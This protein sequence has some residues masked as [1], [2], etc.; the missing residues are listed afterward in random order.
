M[1]GQPICCSAHPESIA[2]WICS[3]ESCRRALCGKCTAHLLKLFTCCDC[4]GPARRLTVSRKT[5]SRGYWVGAAIR[6]PFTAGLPVVIAV[7]LGV[8]A[9]GV[10]ASLIEARPHQL[11]GVVGLVRIAVIVG[12]MLVTIDRTARSAETGQLLRLARIAVGTLCLWLPAASHVLLLG[13]PARVTQHDWP[14]G[15]LA[16]LAVIY[17][18]VV[19][20]VAITDTS[21]ATVS[22]PFKMFECIFRLGRIYLLT[23]ITILL[24]AG[25]SVLGAA[26]ATTMQQ[27]IHTPFLRDA[28]A[29]LPML[30]G[31]AMLCHAIGML[32]HVHGDLIGWGSADLFVDPMYPHMVAEGRRKIVTRPMAVP[33][34]AGDAKTTSPVALVAPRERAEAAKLASALKAGELQSALRIYESRESWSAAS[35]D[36]RQ[37]VNLAKA[38]VRAR[39][40]PLAQ[41]LLEEA[42]AR[43]GRSLGSAW[44]ALAQLHAETLDQP[45][46][47][48]EIYEKIVAELP[49]TDVAKLAASQISNARALVTA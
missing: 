28:V 45:D 49:G 22:N 23:Q 9:L 8:A 34:A 25:L 43:N 4:G 3:T 48:R 1:T 46:K 12:Y 42:C 24:F 36:D 37:L 5:K 10:I 29:Q 17:L 14:L 16:A 40:H 39:K 26:A 13:I 2:G 31:L 44:L 38:A 32:A 33:V 30:V 11:D 19:V 6:Y 15:L 21:F 41:R 35:I 20:A 27:A 47:A 7:A 18:P